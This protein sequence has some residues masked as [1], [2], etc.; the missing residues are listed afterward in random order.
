M[1]ND[2]SFTTDSSAEAVSEDTNVLNQLKAAI[3]KKVQREEIYIP[4]PERPGVMVRI[5]PNIQQAQIRS[6]RRN[7]GEETKKGID[8][9]K[10]SCNVVAA[11]CTG[12]LM[13]DQ[14]VTNDMGV[15]LTFASPEIMQMTNTSR[16]HPDCVLSFFGLEPH[17]EA[18]AV[19]II[20]A[21]GYG[22]TVDAV[23]PTKRSS[24]S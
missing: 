13:N 21:A 19:A 7:A 12:I 18:A 11:T 2:F 9:V 5:S 4:V 17:V 8:T 24:E 22:E 15:E 14:V 20:E 23:D 3:Q 16:P 10:F 1:S 6:W